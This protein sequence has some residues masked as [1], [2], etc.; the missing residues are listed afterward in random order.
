MLVLA[1]IGGSRFQWLAV[2]RAMENRATMK[3]GL[4]LA[5]LFAASTA[6]AQAPG[7]YYEEGAA[8]PGMVAPVVVQ[9]PEPTTTA[10]EGMAGGQVVLTG[11][12]YF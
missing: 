3:L 1:T 11:N 10:R 7:S 6:Y 4:A 8:A 12:Y 9:P 5:S 2:A